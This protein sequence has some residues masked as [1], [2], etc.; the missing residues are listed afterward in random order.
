MLYRSSQDRFITWHLFKAYL[1]N[2]AS[3]QCHEVWTSQFH[4]LH[5]KKDLFHPRGL[6]C[7][8]TSTGHWHWITTNPYLDCACLPPVRGV[9]ALSQRLGSGFM[10]R[11]LLWWSLLVPPWQGSFTSLLNLK[12]FRVTGNQLEVHTLA[13]QTLGKGE[14][15]GQ[16][17]WCVAT[18]DFITFTFIFI[19]FTSWCTSTILNQLRSITSSRCMH[20]MVKG[21]CL[22]LR[23]CPLLFHD[24]SW[25]NIKA[26]MAHHPI[27]QK[28]VDDMLAKGANEP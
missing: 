23:C 12:V 8:V 28:E 2:S 5:S 4:F 9:P 7:M 11:N 18:F 25:F 1:F 10:S 16:H 3:R 17:S 15:W 19:C 21:H 13:T 22:W 24:F 26:A 14:S 20:N 27:I 6:S